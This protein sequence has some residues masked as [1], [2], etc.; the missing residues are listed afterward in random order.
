MIKEP[1]KT[2]LFFLLGHD[3]GLCNLAKN[4]CLPLSAA[5][6]FMNF[7]TIIMNNKTL[8][9][10]ILD[11]SGSMGNCR[12][13]TIDGFNSQ[14]ETVQSLQSEFANQEL[15]LSLT[16]FDDRVD[17]VRNSRTISDFKAL[18][19]TDYFPS[20]QTA[21]LDAIGESIDRIRLV[22]DNEIR[23]DKM[24]V[25]VIIL[26]DGQENASRRFSY[27]QIASQISLLEESGRWTF[28][29]LGAD[30]DAVHTSKMLN[31]RMENVVSFS[32]GDMGEM[33]G[34][35]SRGMHYYSRAKATGKVKKDFLDFMLRKDRRNQ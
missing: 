31:I 19:P 4:S 9:H 13:Q 6:L 12:Q 14:L 29:F 27:H 17:H 24:S 32:K 21:L 16:V 2:G 15:L 30:I 23:D 18:S 1:G 33:M 26:T 28:N 20:G 25:V 7:K 35:V 22:Y 34:N 10:F 5:N 3:I 8:Y 11:K